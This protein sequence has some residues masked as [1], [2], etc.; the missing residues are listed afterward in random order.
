MYLVLF[1]SE[2]VATNLVQSGVLRCFCPAHEEGMVN[3]QV[4]KTYSIILFTINF[5]FHIMLGTSSGSKVICSEICFLAFTHL[6][7]EF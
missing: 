5:H 7:K 6:L 2:P 1:D 3:I 4:K